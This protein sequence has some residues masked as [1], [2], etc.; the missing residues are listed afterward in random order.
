MFTYFNRAVLQGP[1]NEPDSKRNALTCDLDLTSTRLK[2]YNRFNGGYSANT[3]VFCLVAREQDDGTYDVRMVH[4][5]A[6]YNKSTYYYN[7]THMK[8]G[9]SVIQ[10]GISR[11]EAVQMIVD[12]DLKAKEIERGHDQGTNLTV[13]TYRPVIEEMRRAVHNS[14]K[15]GER[16]SSVSFTVD[17]NKSDFL[18]V[19][20]VKTISAPVDGGLDLTKQN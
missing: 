7:D 4:G 19:E 11:E 20:P 17:L 3:D 9:S 15:A 5:F 1:V 16:D 10:S 8:W 12:F 18:T 14:S 6:R 13:T 2:R